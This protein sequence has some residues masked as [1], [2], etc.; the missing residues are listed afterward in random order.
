M[1]EPYSVETQTVRVDDGVD[2][3][4]RVERNVYHARPHQIAQHAA[5]GL[6]VLRPMTGGAAAVALVT[7]PAYPDATRHAP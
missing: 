5:L 1:F 7:R 6:T 2:T 3:P 4:L